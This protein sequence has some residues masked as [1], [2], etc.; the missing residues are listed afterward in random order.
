MKYKLPTKGLYAITPDEANTH[1]LLINVEH[2]LQAGIALLQYRDKT[3]SED[4]KLRRAMALRKLCAQYATPLI[5]NDDPELAYQCQ[6]EGVHLGQGDTC[7]SD[8]REMLGDK[9][10]IGITCH[11]HLDLALKAQKQGANYVAFGRFFNSSTKPGAPLADTTLLLQAK[12][13]L[14][15]PITAIGGLTLEN[16]TPII[17]A[18]ADNIA[19][20]EA[21]FSK[22]NIK[23]ACENFSRLF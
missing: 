21:I 14:N 18:G 3:S 8:A 11:H 1:Q 22:E 6:A 17:N 5:I 4:K 23:D 13:Q 15:I 10:I 19:V 7:I 12:A 2:A 16:S 20:V 9:A